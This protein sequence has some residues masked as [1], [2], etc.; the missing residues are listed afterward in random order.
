MTTRSFMGLHVEVTVYEDD[1]WLRLNG[2]SWVMRMETAG[3]DG[4]IVVPPEDLAAVTITLRRWMNGELIIQLKDTEVKGSSAMI[5]Y[6]GRRIR[7]IFTRKQQAAFEFLYAFLNYWIALCAGEAL[8][9]ADQKNWPRRRMTLPD[10]WRIEY[11]RNPDGQVVFQFLDEFD[12]ASGYAAG[13]WAKLE[14]TKAQLRAGESDLWCPEEVAAARHEI[15]LEEKLV[16]DEGRPIRIVIQ[17]GEPV[18]FV[19]QEDGNVTMHR[20]GQGVE[21]RTNLE[22]LIEGLATD[23]AP[24]ELTKAQLRKSEELWFP[25]LEEEAQ[26]WLARH[27]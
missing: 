23:L 1:G 27:S 15:E 11:M 26:A 25:E 10:G 16:D 8:V 18:T 7:L 4:D 19:R 3:H 6:K 20:A 12:H 5:P 2:T 17:A 13:L 9:R 14:L 22:K 21:G 24:M